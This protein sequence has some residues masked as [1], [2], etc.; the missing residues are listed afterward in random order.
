MLA[1]PLAQDYVEVARPPADHYTDGCGLSHIPGGGLLATFLYESR[2]GTPRYCFNLA[3]SDDGGCSWE[4]L[5]QLEF[6]A[7]QPFVHDG[8]LYL[9]GNN[10]GPLTTDADG[11]EHHPG[12]VQARDIA[13]CRSDDGGESWTDP[14]TLFAGRYWNAPTGMA[15]ANGQ[16]YRAFNVPDPA[17]GDLD[18]VGDRFVVAAG[19]LSADLLDPAAWRLS[20]VVEFPGVPDSLSRDLNR[21]DNKWLEPNVVA[22]KGRLQVLHRMRIDYLATAGMCAVCDLDD[23][24]RELDC[25]FAQF[26]PMPGGQ[27]KFFIIY[28]EVSRLFWTPSNLVTNSQDVVWGEQ[29]KTIGFHQAP[30]NER[31]ILMLLY[32]VDA[33]NWFEAGCIAMSTN[34]KESFHYAAPLVDREDLLIL[35]RTSSPNA[36]HQHD[37]DLVTFHRITDFHKLALN[38]HPTM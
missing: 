19:D 6:C 13:I 7:A 16:L 37:S 23:D 10:S 22:Y 18:A 15:V 14:V 9:L 33:L 2:L 3:R 8:A 36:R 4:P 17:I 35:S 27:C 1:E 30:G 38:L 21:C 20:P 25:R 26:H 11:R 32:G 5:P 28:D 24:G 29:L 34:P 12:A 31:R